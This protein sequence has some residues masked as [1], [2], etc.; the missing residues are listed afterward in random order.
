MVK[1]EKNKK[2]NIIVK[3]CKLIIKYNLKDNT[4]HDKPD[5]LRK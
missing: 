4:K 3:L 5:C 2:L 1:N